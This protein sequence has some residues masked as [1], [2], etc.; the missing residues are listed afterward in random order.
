MSDG[1]KT[2]LLGTAVAMMVE[3]AGIALLVTGQMAAGIG[4]VVLGLLID[5]VAISRWRS[6]GR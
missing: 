6:M 4:L 2:L 1:Q 3:I 5:L